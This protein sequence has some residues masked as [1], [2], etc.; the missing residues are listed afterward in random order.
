LFL[1]PSSYIDIATLGNLTKYTGGH[2]YYYP[3]F[4]VQKSEDVE[5]FSRDLGRFLTLRHGLEAVLRIR[6]SKGLQVSSYHGNFFTRSADLLG[7]ANVNPDHSYSIDISVTETLEASI[8]C[9]QTA[10]LHTTNCG[11]RRI[12][13]LTLALPVSSNPADLLD[14]ADSQAIADLY[15]KQAV[16]LVWRSTKLEA[17]REFFFNKCVDIFAAQRTLLGTTSSP[18]IM[19]TNSLRILPSLLLGATKCV[20]FRGG[21]RTLSDHRSYVLLLLKS[22]SVSE[23]SMLFYPTMYSIHDIPDECGVWNGGNMLLPAPLNSSAEKIERHGVYL[24]DNMTEY[25]LWVGSGVHP[26]VCQG[27][28][29]H[30]HYERLIAGK[31]LLPDLDSRYSIRLKGMISFLDR[32]YGRCAHVYLVK[33]DGD[34]TCKMQ[35]ISGLVE[36]RTDQSLSYA[37]WLGQMREK[38]FAATNH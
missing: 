27:I 10:L 22:L 37:Q 15:A 31:I 8:A 21:S 17:I 29:G 28:F 32:E 36:D 3:G 30:Q 35:F 33:E 14:H 19:T 26:E 2:L 6:A 4:Q 9:V 5:K 20:G 16:D 18:H 1:F 25:Y 11:E 23:S 13:V 12:R 34:M 24:L 38:V 7:L